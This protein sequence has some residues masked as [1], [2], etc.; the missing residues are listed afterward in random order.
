[1]S[2]QL[3]Y[4]WKHHCYQFGLWGDLKKWY[5]HSIVLALFLQKIQTK[6]DGF[7]MHNMVADKTIWLHRENRVIQT[8]LPMRLDFLSVC[9]LVMPFKTIPGKL[10]CQLFLSQSITFEEKN[11]TKVFNEVMLFLSCLGPQKPYNLDIYFRF[12]WHFCTAL[13]ANCF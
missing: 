13:Q 4:G 3:F 10:Y 2:K 12:F 5:E 11:S 8:L 7:K 1:M 6:G 9:H